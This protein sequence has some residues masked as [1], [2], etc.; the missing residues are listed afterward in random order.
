M[1]VYQ[2][3]CRVVGISLIQTPFLPSC[4]SMTFLR[5]R[6]FGLDMTRE[7]SNLQVPLL[8]SKTTCNTHGVGYHGRSNLHL[9]PCCELIPFTSQP[10][11]SGVMFRMPMI[12]VCSPRLPGDGVFLKVGPPL[13]M[14]RPSFTRKMNQPYPPTWQWKSPI[15]SWCSNFNLHLII[16]DLR[17]PRLIA[18][19][20]LEKHKHYLQVL[21]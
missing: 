4:G 17:L 16:G 19:G 7:G 18:R 8:E 3:V 5:F 13:S 1:L 11:G 21:M 10:C 2:R 15:D 6:D 14:L 20:Y 9:W 12:S